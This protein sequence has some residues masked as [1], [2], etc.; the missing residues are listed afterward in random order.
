[1]FIKSME[2][3]LCLK[4]ILFTERQMRMIAT[5]GINTQTK[6]MAREA[7]R[8]NCITRLPESAY[9]EEEK[10]FEL[11]TKANNLLSKIIRG[12]MSEWTKKSVSF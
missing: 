4:E 6:R 7:I 5:S 8:L 2:E 3:I 9:E 12:G 10:E 11:R 1:M